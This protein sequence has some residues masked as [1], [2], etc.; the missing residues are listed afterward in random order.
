[1]LGL[2]AVADVLK[3]EAAQAVQELQD[4]GRCV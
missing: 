3:E 4:L 2:I 1:M